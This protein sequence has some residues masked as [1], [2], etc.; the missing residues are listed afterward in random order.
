MSL[1]S[2]DDIRNL[3]DQ[4][5]EICVSLYLPTHRTGL[6]VRQNSIRFKDLLRRAE[7]RLNESG[8]AGTNR[9]RFC[10]GPPSAGG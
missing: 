10:T 6:E 3:V 8:C 4:H 9:K 5:P 1:I 2:K 7:S